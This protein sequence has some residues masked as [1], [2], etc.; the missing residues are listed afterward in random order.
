MRIHA[1]NS[2]EIFSSRMDLWC[3]RHFK[4]KIA[5]FDILFRHIYSWSR[6]HFKGGGLCILAS[7]AEVCDQMDKHSCFLVCYCV[8]LDQVFL[9]VFKNVNKKALFTSCSHLLDLNLVESG[10]SEQI[11]KS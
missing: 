10:C 11:V 8:I 9:G 7:E 5:N 6:K 4:L 2:A 1:E 3:N